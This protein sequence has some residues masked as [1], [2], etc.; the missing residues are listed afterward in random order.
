M[1][2]DSLN[3]IAL[4]KAKILYNFGLSECNRVKVIP[5]SHFLSQGRQLQRYK[6]VSQKDNAAMNIHLYRH[7]TK[8]NFLGHY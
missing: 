3:L 2:T 5:M 7:H 4:K 6:I 8:L 1:N